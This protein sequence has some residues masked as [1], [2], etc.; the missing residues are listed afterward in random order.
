MPADCSKV[1]L[2]ERAFSHLLEASNSEELL[3]IREAINSTSLAVTLF[4]STACSVQRKGL[5]RIA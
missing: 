1:A 2:E 4:F 3:Q 5:A